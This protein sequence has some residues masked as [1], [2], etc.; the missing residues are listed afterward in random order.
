MLALTLTPTLA[1][2]LC[3]ER[4][5]LL[6]TTYCLLLAAYYLLLTTYYLLQAFPEKRDYDERLKALIEALQAE[7]R[8]RTERLAWQREWETE[9]ESVKDHAVKLQPVQSMAAPSRDHRKSSTARKPEDPAFIGS[10]V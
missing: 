2:T 4:L 10:Q 3:Q 1:L 5:Y 7:E 6:L 9:W 8:R